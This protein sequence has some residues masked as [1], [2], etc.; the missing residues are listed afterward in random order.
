METAGR[1][2]LLGPERVEELTSAQFHTL[3]EFFRGLDEGVLVYPTHVHGSPC[4]ASI[5][6][7]LCSTIGY[8]FLHSELLRQPTEAKFREMA[9]KNLPPKP[10]YYPR[11]KELNT[12]SP[13][14]AADSLVIRALPPADFK[15]AV[16]DKANVLV[17]TRHMLAFGGG[18]IPGAL[19]IGAAGPLSIQAGWM[20]EPDRP[21]LLVVESDAQ[22]KTVLHHFARTGFIRFAGY[23]AGGMSAW[24]NAGY[25]LESLP[26]LHVQ[27]LAAR[28]ASN[29]EAVVLDVRSPQE[30]AKGQVRG[31]RHIFLPELPGQL[32]SLDKRKPTAVYCDSGYRASIAAS[33]LQSHGFEVSN[34]PGSVQA[35]RSSGLPM[36]VP[37]VAGTG[38]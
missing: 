16:A 3:Y 11:L 24:E 5:G 25:D 10:R 22:L 27:D 23:L 36:E 7:K 8:E 28:V 34:V 33:F 19:N 15:K 30:W 14:T 20:L 32:E 17:D 6:D 35:W 18:H 9:L 37:D 38:S 1:T 26:Q 12:D 31:A 13:A 4:G 29:A 21:I 2:D